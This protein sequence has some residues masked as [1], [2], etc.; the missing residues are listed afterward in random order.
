MSNPIPPTE[1]AKLTPAALVFIT[2][3]LV[4]IGTILVTIGVGVTLGWAWAITVLGALV[5]VYGL[6]TGK[7]V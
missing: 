3:L 6:L 5:I 2:V 1:Q 4:F 7:S